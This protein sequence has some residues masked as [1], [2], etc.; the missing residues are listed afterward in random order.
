MKAVIFDF[1][2]IKSENRTIWNKVLHT[3]NLLDVEKEI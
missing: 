3:D 1:D 2:D